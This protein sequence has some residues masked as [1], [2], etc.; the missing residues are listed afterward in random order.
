MSDGP[1]KYHACYDFLK[2]NKFSF[3]THSTL[4]SKVA[5]VVGL[6]CV[7]LLVVVALVMSAVVVNKRNKRPE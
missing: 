3:T 1:N 7:G 2:L 4:G 6:S 5:L